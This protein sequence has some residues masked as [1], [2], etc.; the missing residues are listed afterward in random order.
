MKPVFSGLVTYAWLPPKT[1]M[2]R[3]KFLAEQDDFHASSVLHFS[4]LAHFEQNA[5]SLE[6]SLADMIIQRNSKY[7]L[8]KLFGNSCPYYQIGYRYQHNLI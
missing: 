8:F 1:M 2:L 4:Q 7:P 6:W 3:V 5:D